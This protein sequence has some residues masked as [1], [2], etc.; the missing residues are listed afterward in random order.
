M[1]ERVT[2]VLQIYHQPEE[3]EMMT[4]RYAEEFDRY[5]GDAGI[6]LEDEDGVED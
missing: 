2:E 6:E 3:Q 1:D 5:V 4:V